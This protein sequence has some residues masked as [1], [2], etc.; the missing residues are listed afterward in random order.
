MF[1]REVVYGCQVGVRFDQKVTLT[2]WAGKG[3]FR[4]GWGGW[5][6]GWRGRGRGA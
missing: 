5:R 3:K 6:D 4:E 2:T 1:V